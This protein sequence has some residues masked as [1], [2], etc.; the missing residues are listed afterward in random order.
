MPDIF[1]V[2]KSF[3]YVRAVVVTSTICMCG[4]LEFLDESRDLM[5]MGN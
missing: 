3:L 4:L 5:N 1:L 2:R